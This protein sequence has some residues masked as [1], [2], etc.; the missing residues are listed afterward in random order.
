M[1][2]QFPTEAIARQHS[3]TSLMTGDVFLVTIYIRISASI[4][5]MEEILLEEDVSGLLA[6][7]PLGLEVTSLFTDKEEQHKIIGKGKDLRWLSSL[8]AAGKDNQQGET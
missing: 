1:V 2:V 8:E 5:R 4:F 3:L 7:V 6:L